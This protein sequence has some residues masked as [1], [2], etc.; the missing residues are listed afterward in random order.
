MK[1]LNTFIPNCVTSSKAYMTYLRFTYF[2]LDETKKA[3]FD[4]GIQ[5]YSKKTLTN[6]LQGTESNDIV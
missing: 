2:T 5:I 1:I 3:Y 6:I 4:T